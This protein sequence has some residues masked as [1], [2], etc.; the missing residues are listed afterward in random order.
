[1]L[2]TVHQTVAELAAKNDPSLYLKWLYQCK[3]MLS[4][5]IPL[6]ELI[7][8]R[9]HTDVSKEEVEEINVTLQKEFGTSE[10]PDTK[11]KVREY[12]CNGTNS[13]NIHLV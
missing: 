11:Q 13:I 3:H 7:I 12:L 1:M 6:L 5:R 10:A 8:L 9:W 4:E 2:V